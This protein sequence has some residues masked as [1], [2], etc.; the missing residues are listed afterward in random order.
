MGQS[1]Y[2]SHV[3]KSTKS[4]LFKNL[5][6]MF[7]LMVSKINISNRNTQNTRQINVAETLSAVTIT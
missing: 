7:Y 1:I 6:L 4:I 2:W 5:L 3:L